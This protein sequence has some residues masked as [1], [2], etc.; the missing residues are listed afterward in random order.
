VSVAA[1]DGG[2]TAVEDTTLQAATGGEPAAQ[3]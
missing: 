3:V 2:L 1:M